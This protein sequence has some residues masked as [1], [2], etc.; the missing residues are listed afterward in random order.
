MWTGALPNGSKPIKLL[1]PIRGELSILAAILTLGHNAAYGRTYFRLLVT[2]PTRLPLSQL[3][4]AICSLLMLCIMLPLFVTSFKT[5]RK[6]M[7]GASWKKLQRLA[8]GFYALLYLHVMLLFVPSALS[9][10]RGYLLSVLVYS[11]VFLGYAVCRVLKAHAVKLRQSD[12]LPRRQMFAAAGAL[13]LSLCLSGAMLAVSQT[14]A[15]AETVPEAQESQAPETSSI[16]ES[17]TVSEPPS[18]E[19]EQQ[20]ADTSEAVSTEPDAAEPSQAADSAPAETAAEPTPSATSTP[21]PSA[22]PAAT[23]TPAPTTAPAVA[24]TPAPAATATPEPTPTPTP[25]PTPEPVRAYKNGTFTG[26]GQGYNG[27]ITVSVTIQ[28]DVITAISVTSS[29]DDEPF[30]SDAEAVIRRILSAQST[31]VD[32]VSGA[33][34]SSGGIL[35]AVDAAL[36]SAKN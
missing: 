19:P 30:L 4:A 9:G 6:R 31:K 2:N 12:A 25:T 17:A 33:T 22:A 26:T 32:A 29:S 27:P 8:Y 28:D 7:K 36:K 3:L 21:A 5:V 34:C 1:M 24:A 18:A 11:A 20:E 13:V 10:K 15:L 23:A 16:P 35:D 14:S